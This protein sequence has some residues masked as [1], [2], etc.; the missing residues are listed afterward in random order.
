MLDCSPAKIAEYTERYGFE[1]W[2]LRTPLTAYSRA[3][4][5]YGLDN[6]CFKTFERATWERLLTETEGDCPLWACCPDIVGDAARTLELFDY[7]APKMPDVPLAL[8]I[9]DGIE[10]WPIPWERFRCVFIGG[11]TPFK[12][13]PQALAV[14]KAA[15]MM[16]KWVHVGRVNTALRLRNWIGLADSIDGSGMSRFDHMLEDCLAVIKGEHPQHELGV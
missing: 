16:G 9:Q 8:V 1:F 6:G 15:K 12:S 4:V 13:S 5:P 3:P 7:F 2:Q 11:S 14:A 10:N